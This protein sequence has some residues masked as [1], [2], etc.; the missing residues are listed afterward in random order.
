MRAWRRLPMTDA[1]T[2]RRA[3][4]GSW[5]RHARQ[6]Q[7]PP[8]GDH[9]SIW[10]LLAGRGAG[11]TRSIC[12]FVLSEIAK[13]A[14]RV[15]LVA[16][17]ASDARSVLV[18]GESGILSIAPAWN[19]PHYSPGL[20]RLT[21]KNGAIATLYSA[22]EPERLRGPQHDLAA[23]DELCAWRRPSAWDQLQFTMRLPG[24][25]PPRIAI[26]TTPKPTRLLKELLLREGR[27]VVVSRSTSYENRE[28]LAPMFF[29]QIVRKYEGSRLGRQELL[30][31]LLDDVEGALWNRALLDELRR[32]AAPVMQRIVVGIDPSGSGNKTADEVGIVAC[33]VDE[34]GM[35]WVLADESGKMAPIDWA[36]RAVELYRRLQADRIVAEQNFGGEMVEAVIRS[37]DANI[38]YTAVTAS[39]SK[40]V[41]AEPISALFEQKRVFLLGAFPELEDEMCE[42]TSNFDRTT[43]GYSPGRLDA[44]VW[45]LTDLMVTATP[46]QG[47]LDYYHERALAAG[48][49]P[50]G[51]DASGEVA[52]CL[53]PVSLL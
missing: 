51:A 50:E 16:A 19:R 27:D 35:G 18:E 22:D 28:N 6:S 52:A 31:E 10:L 47:I 7:L 30:A 44:M 14:R 48:W 42:F 34:A 49:K 1:A 36:R 45:A 53:N 33:A 39:R 2:L 24:K 38:P 17:T 40:V 46:F 41:R 9:W 32:E 15:A 8:A 26:A 43:A 25:R 5:R 4:E 23:V 20:R 13:G 29:E 11:K 3:L 12:E 37:V 21:W